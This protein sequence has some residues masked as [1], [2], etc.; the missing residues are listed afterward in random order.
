MFQSRGGGVGA[1][2]ESSAVFAEEFGEGGDFAGA[3]LALGRLEPGPF[4]SGGIVGAAVFDDAGGEDAGGFDE[5]S[6]VEKDEGL[7][8]DVAAGAVG[9]AFFARRCIEGEHG[10]V[11]VAALPPGV[12]AAAPDVFVGAALPLADGEVEI[13]P[14]AGRLVGFHA[15][16]AGALHEQAGNGEGVVAHELGI[17]PPAAA[18]GELAVLGITRQHFR[19]GDGR[20]RVGFARDHEADHVAQVP[21]ALHEF[22][23]QPVEERLVRGDFALRAEVVER[24][25]QPAA[26]E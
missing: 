8:R 12:E 3:W 18:A 25:H 21:A 16:A 23:G 19:R 14:I 20:A 4:K 17:E 13:F 1:Q 11:D 15:G 6:V 22:A 24:L 26:V 7:L 2:V 5:L 10:G 9:G